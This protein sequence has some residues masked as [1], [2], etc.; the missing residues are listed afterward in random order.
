M[1]SEPF[2]T[3]Q[4][5]VVNLLPTQSHICFVIRKLFTSQDCQALLSEDVKD[6]FQKAITNYPTS[7]RNNDRFVNDNQQLARELF[8][9]VKPYLPP[10]VNIQSDNVAESGMWE[11][12]E[13]NSRI[14]Y[15]R[16]S[17]GQYFNRHLDG[18]HYRSRE[19]Q[20]KLTFMIYLNGADEFTGGRTLFLSF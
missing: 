8:D 12:Q 16:Y 6:S 18:V 11:L 14:R 9:R 15:C 7:Y 19:V 5:G 20:S 13:L 17:S 3:T 4:H 2:M 10:T 1:V